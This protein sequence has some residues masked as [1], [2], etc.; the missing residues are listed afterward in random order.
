VDTGFF[1]GISVIDT[2]SGR[3]PADTSRQVLRLAVPA[4]LALVAEPAFL[5]ADSAVV[6]RLGIEPLAGLGVASTLLFTAVGVFVFLAYGTTATVAR[7]VGSGDVSAALGLGVDGLWLALLLGVACGLLLAGFA[8]P[9]VRVFGA[10]DRAG[11]QAIT[12]LRISAAGLPGMLMVLAGTGVLRG[13]RDAWTPLV[14]S[15]GGFSLNIALNVLL[16]LGLRLGI[17]G[18]ALGTVAAQT[19]MAGALTVVVVRGVRRHRATLRPHPW[20]VLSAARAGTPLLVRTVALRAVFLISTWVA[21]SGG[22]VTLAAYQVSSTV[23]VFL[24]FALDALAIAA[25]SLTGHALGAADAAGARRLTALMVRW[26]AIGGGLLAAL[27]LALHRVLPALFTTDPAVRS[28]LAGALLVVAVQQPLCGLVF[29]LDGVLIGAG[30]GRW[31]AGAAVAQ[32]VLYLPVALLVR[33]GGAGAV[34][35]WWGLGAFMLCRGLLLAWRASGDAWVVLGAG[36]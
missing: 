34:L 36:S 4:F 25:Q 32:L 27:V 3:N 20:R 2:T 15:V 6:G 17:A 13:L 5:L 14:V 19:A 8:E 33:A 16:V 23:W 29:V 18:S 31:L 11:E 22:D 28:A 21:A 24:A 10:S 35:L 9:V 12:Y 26:G 1:R 7:R 30:D